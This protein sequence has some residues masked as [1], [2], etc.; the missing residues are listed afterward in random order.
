MT[1]N[2][3]SFGPKAH[4][5]SNT[6]SAVERQPED[7]RQR[8]PQNGPTLRMG[9]RAQIGHVAP[10]FFQIIIWEDDEGVATWEAY[11]MPHHQANHGAI[12]EQ[13]VSIRHIE[14]MTG[15]DFLS[16]IEVDEAERV[17]TYASE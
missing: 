9:S 1:P 17:S 6:V 3:S 7:Q 15:L 13:L 5:R 10:M 12:K 8:R 16:E 14:A 11:M 4:L 2:R